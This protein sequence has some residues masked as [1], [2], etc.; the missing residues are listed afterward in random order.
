MKIWVTQHGGAFHAALGQIAA[1]PASFLINILV[2]SASLF[3]PFFG[4]IALDNLRP[5]SA[6]MTV[7][8]EV[9]L[10]LTPETGRE[11]ALSIQPA[12]TAAAKQADPAARVVFVPRERALAALEDRS[13]LS[14]ALGTLDRNPLPDAYIITLTSLDRPSRIAK[15]ATLVGA[16]EKLPGVDTVQMDADWIKRLAALLE[17][18]RFLL[19][20]VGAAVGIVVVAVTFNTVR[21][22]I[23]V[24]REQI[25]VAR[26]VGATDAFIRRPFQY[27]GALM[28]LAAGLLTVLAVALTLIPINGMVSQFARLYGSTYTISMPSWPV[29]AFLLAVAALLGFIG[30]AMSVRRT[31]ADFP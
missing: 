16:L 1:A 18:G 23:L 4:L 12:V 29:V 11:A 19:L 21:L 27:A 28:G 15:S 3:L 8:P 10:F 2:L 5:V 26:L 9:S 24:Q 30:A 22:Q 31:L 13:G 6:S 14:E 20:T 25:A 7:Q 17:L